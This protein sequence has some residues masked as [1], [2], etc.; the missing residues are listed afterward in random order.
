M[1]ATDQHSSGMHSQREFAVYFAATM[2]IIMLSI[3]FSNYAA[4]HKHWYFLPEAAATIFV[5]MC[6]GVLYVLHSDSVTESLATFDPSIF[7]VGLLPPIIFNSGYTM[8]RRFFFDNITAI[9]TYAVAGTTISSF[10]VGVIVYVAGYCGISLKL[11]LAE[12]L[13]F[14]A[15]ISATDTVSVLAIF[16]ELRVEPTLFYLVFG[17]SSLN[18]AVA[19]VLFESFSKFIGNSFTASAIPTAIFD[20]TFIFIGS[21]LVGIVFGMLSALLFKHFSFK[22]CLYQE[23]SVYIMFSY[24]PFSVC[25]VCDLSG[26]VAILFTG[27]SMKHYTCNNLS[28]EGKASV[29][30]FFNAISYVSEATIF[31][32]LGLA[33]FSLKQGFHLSFTTW[34]LFAC[35]VG[36][37]LHVYPLTYLL[38]L[39][40]A[41]DRKIPLATQHMIWFSGLRGALCFALALE[42]PNE[43]Q[44]QEII[45]VTM[46][47]VLITLFI[48][49][50]ATVPVLNYLKIKRLT[51]TEELAIDQ[52]VRPMKRMSILQFDAKY[53]VPF[54]TN[55]HP[56]VD[57][58]NTTKPTDDHPSPD[59]LRSASPTQT[60]PKPAAAHN[61]DEDGIDF[62]NMH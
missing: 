54:F 51:P 32:N 5:G 25:T 26:V 57:E 43:L 20:F 50:G 45:T 46:I 10:V 15:L 29:A 4:H 33:V 23:V 12:A 34:T 18:D 49:G 27:I 37:A 42:W 31:L 38:N 30:K 35:L 53:L 8:K 58:G 36:R 24:L 28:E 3:L 60:A 59:Q 56:E 22:G 14:G 40:K 62:T 61:E 13:S 7:F 16:Q 47:I 52:M 17:E 2:I 9:V 39:R 55:L 44:R 48:G 41:A 19:I 6:G 1:T 11:T 21:T